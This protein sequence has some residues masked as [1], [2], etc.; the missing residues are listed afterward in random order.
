MKRLAQG[1]L[2][3]VA[4][5]LG[6]ALAAPAALSQGRYYNRGTVPGVS[7]SAAQRERVAAIRAETQ[8]RVQRIRRSPYLTA[9]QKE[10]RIAAE[11]RR[12]NDRVMRILTPSQRSA[13]RQGGYCAGRVAGYRAGPGYGRGRGYG[14][15]RGYG[16]GYDYNRGRMRG[17]DR[18]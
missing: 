4:V 18:R 10:A 2:L 13:C 8:R 11:R 1:G 16:R 14:Y 7:L 6:L 17:R 15:G 3:A 5:L 9:Q 12:G